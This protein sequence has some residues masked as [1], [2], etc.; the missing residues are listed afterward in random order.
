M[1]KFLSSS[2]LDIQEEKIMKNEESKKFVDL[3]IEFVVT[4]FYG[5][6]FLALW[7]WILPDMISDM[8]PV[9]NDFLALAKGV[10]AKY[11]LLLAPVSVVILFVGKK[12]VPFLW[13]KMTGK[14]R[15]EV[16]KILCNR[17][18]DKCEKVYGAGKKLVE[19]IKAKRNFRELCRN[20]KKR[21]WK[22]KWDA[23]GLRC[24]VPHLKIR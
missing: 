3:I 14:H 10:S 9:V 21:H 1:I 23:M 7:K 18:K 2:S 20:R 12:F 4:S 5:F 24:F 15:E 17:F 6:C 8:P 11:Q 22:R 13:E 16:V 19:K